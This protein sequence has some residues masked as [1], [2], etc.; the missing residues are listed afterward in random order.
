MEPRPDQ[1]HIPS[2]GIMTATLKRA[3][4]EMAAAMIIRVHQLRGDTEWKPVGLREVGEW[5]KQ[6][7][8]MQRWAACPVFNPDFRTLIDAGYADLTD[9]DTKNSSLMVNEKFVAA[10]RRW[11]RP[12]AP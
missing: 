7:P 1:L 10:M 12:D 4:P 5:L 9:P 8:E 6:D 3:E 2:T 11:Q